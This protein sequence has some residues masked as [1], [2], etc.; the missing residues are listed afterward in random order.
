MRAGFPAPRVPGTVSCA[1]A[2]RGP[3]TAAPKMPST[4][5]RLMPTKIPLPGDAQKS[6]L[7]VNGCCRTTQ[8]A[9]VLPMCPWEAEHDI[10]Q[11]SGLEHDATSDEYPASDY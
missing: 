7:T 5:R 10:A 6:G 3:I 9:S 11:T 4:S 8:P 2:V 1:R